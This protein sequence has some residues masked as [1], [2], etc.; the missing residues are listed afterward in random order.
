MRPSVRV[1]DVVYAA[2]QL[3]IQFDIKYE[4]VDAGRRPLRIVKCQDNTDTR[5]EIMEFHSLQAAYEYLVEV[6]VDCM[7]I[8]AAG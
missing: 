6:C 2:R 3:D 7:R 5:P 4:L 8:L 1:S